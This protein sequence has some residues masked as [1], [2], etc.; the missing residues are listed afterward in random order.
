MW[1]SGSN[2]DQDDIIKSESPTQYQPAVLHNWPDRSFAKIVIAIIGRGWNSRFMFIQKVS[3]KFGFSAAKV[4]FRATSN[5]NLLGAWAIKALLLIWPKKEE[6]TEI[7]SAARDPNDDLV[8]SKTADSDVLA[9]ISLRSAHILMQGCN[10]DH[11]RYFRPRCT[12]NKF[13]MLTLQT[14]PRITSYYTYVYLKN[15]IRDG[16]STALY[17]A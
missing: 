9:L 5:V 2:F 8:G 6:K 16:G 1:W 7:F 11:A 14:Y 15:T 3:N 10:F 13:D 12:A 17:T 4:L